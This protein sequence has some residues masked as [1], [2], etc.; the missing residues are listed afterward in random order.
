[1][2][3]LVG[4]Q[5]G[6]TGKSPI[7]Q[8][9]TV[10]LAR[11]G[12]RVLLVDADLQGT[13]WQWSRIR[14]ANTKLTTI[15]CMQLRGADLGAKVLELARKFDDV[16]IDAGGQ[17]STE[18]RS[19]MTVAEL[20]VSPFK[21]KQSDLWTVERLAQLV[22]TVKQV[23][24]NP[25]MRATVVISQA[26]T[27][28]KE[29]S[30]GDAREFIEQYGLEVVAQTANLKAYDDAEREGR[31]VLEYEG[32]QKGP[33]KAKRETEELARRLYSEQIQQAGAAAA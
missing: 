12:R 27:N 16:V 20:L 32:S 2:I 4:G 23:G 10:W 3:T 22:R 33:L 9:M 8:N 24:G 5:K 1:M 29:T 17:D 6:G 31:G 26:P 30:A 13:S 11:T 21:A 15:T 19:A 14:G 18:L 7:A 28:W 25:G